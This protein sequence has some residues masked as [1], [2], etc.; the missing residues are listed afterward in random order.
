MRPLFFLLLALPAMSQTPVETLDAALQ[1]RFR[2]DAPGAA[3]LVVQNGAVL[4]RK[5]YGL[6]RLDTPAP[7]TPTT[8][9]RM[10][11]V[12]K[13]FTAM[14]VLLLAEHGKLNLNDS[15]SRFFPDFNPTVGNRV[16]LRHL[17]THTS[18]LLDY[19]EKVDSTTFQRQV[20]DADVLT[21]VQAHPTTY[22]EPGSEFRYS[23]TGF[24]LLSLVVEKAS[25]E[26]FG[27]F[28]AENMF[29]PLGMDR[30][31]LY[32]TAKAHPDRALGYA[33][34]GAGRIQPSDQSLTSAT[35]GDGCVYTCLDDY[36]AWAEALRRNRLLNLP[37]W[38]DKIA[39]PVKK[40]TEVRYGLGWFFS[41]KTPLELSHTGSTCGFS[42][43]VWLVPERNLAVV[44]FSNLADAHGEFSAVEILARTLSGESPQV[45]WSRVLEATR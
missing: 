35:R 33:R 44:Y 18:G 4:L 14:A 28:L 34:D 17:L 38:L 2:A 43:G 24:C 42:N 39:S 30:T 32:E 6:A 20:L 13:Q 10:A 37:K 3:V 25:G 19:E 31:A 27:Q 9:F 16:R 23:N 12:S 1:A 41:E 36:L 21:L 8:L 29:R 22:F 7:I 5:G 45:L 15:L 26:P 40:G 11:S